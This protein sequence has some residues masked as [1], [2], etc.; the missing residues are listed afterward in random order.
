MRTPAGLFPSA[1][2]E[3]SRRA[4]FQHRRCTLT[5][6][7]RRRDTIVPRRPARGPAPDASL[8]FPHRFERNPGFIGL[9]LPNAIQTRDSSDASLLMSRLGAAD[10]VLFPPVNLHHFNPHVS[11]DDVGRPPAPLKCQPTEQSNVSHKKLLKAAPNASA[12]QPLTAF[13][14]ART[15]TAPAPTTNSV[16]T[17]LCETLCNSFTQ[18]HGEREKKQKKKHTQREPTKV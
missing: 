3:T 6:R 7:P 4:L 13:M 1:A 2:R 8:S 9:F 5:D 14:H 17:A 15:F 18:P 11:G 12:G 16:A 10:L